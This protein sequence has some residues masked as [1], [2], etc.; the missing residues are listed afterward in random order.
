MKI[1]GQCSICSLFKAVFLGPYC[2]CDS[3][4]DMYIFKEAWENLFVQ[5]NDMLQ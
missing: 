4:G 5:V 3:P 1:N 2:A